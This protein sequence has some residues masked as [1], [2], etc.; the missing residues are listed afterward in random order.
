MLYTNTMDTLAQTVLRWKIKYVCKK[1]CA[2]W[3]SH[4]SQY[5]GDNM[6]CHLRYTVLLKKFSREWWVLLKSVWKTSMLMNVYE[7]HDLK[8][9]R[10]YS[11]IFA[12][13]VILSSVWCTSS[14]SKHVSLLWSK[15]CPLCYLKF[16]WQYFCTV[17]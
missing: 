14:R 13:Q 8:L 2:S 6:H 15:S 9:T 1:F 16:S 3:S 12:P 11:L 7:C 5:Q 10:L 4:K 17:L